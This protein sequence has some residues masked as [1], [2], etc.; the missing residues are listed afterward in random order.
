MDEEPPIRV[1]FDRA[2]RVLEESG[3]QG[4]TAFEA[5]L[6]DLGQDRDMEALFRSRESHGTS[7][8]PELLDPTV[9]QFIQLEAEL[10]RLV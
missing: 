4:Q 9:T 3:R 1:A 7:R 2:V 6:S 10:G 5:C 8:R